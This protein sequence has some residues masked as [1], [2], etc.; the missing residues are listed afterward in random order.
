M[1]R[2]Q[3]EKTDAEKNN[4]SNSSTLISF[5]DLEWKPLTRGTSRKLHF[6]L[7]PGAP[8]RRRE[9]P[10]APDDWTNPGGSTATDAAASTSATARGSL[11]PETLL[12]TA[13]RPQRAWGARACRAGVPSRVTN[14]SGEG[15]TCGRAGAIPVGCLTGTWLSHRHV[16]STRPLPSSAGKSSQR[17]A[18]GL[19]RPQPHADSGPQGGVISR[20]WVP[21]RRAGESTRRAEADKEQGPQD[22]R[23][24]KIFKQIA[25]DTH[26]S[27]NKE[28]MT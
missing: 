11:F 19:K 24:H 10:T 27:Q 8:S 5:Q 4:F 12:P 21:A 1:L 18:R 14:S 22:Q 25:T 23:G 13:S 7:A 6:I 28:S 20:P 9:V 3:P 26:M 17:E 15:V 16:A 2:L